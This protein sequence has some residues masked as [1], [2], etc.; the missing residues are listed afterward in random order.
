MLHR[1]TPLDVQYLFIYVLYRCI[2]V[3]S[4]ICTNWCWDAQQCRCLNKDKFF[5]PEAPRLCKEPAS[6]T[7]ALACCDEGDFCNVHVRPP[8][9]SSE[10]MGKRGL[11][12]D[13]DVGQ[14]NVWHPLTATHS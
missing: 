5:P 8:L 14:G 4:V 10:E 6:T 11:F 2:K 12:P 3:I 13:Y 1:F 7:E 9:L